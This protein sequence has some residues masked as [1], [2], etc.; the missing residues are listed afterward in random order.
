VCPG[1]SHQIK[2]SRVLS[3]NICLGGSSGKGTAQD[4]RLV[5]GS[6][7]SPPENF[8]FQIARDAI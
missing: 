7:G 5:V 4:G 8:E 6:G 2:T 3:R 1:G